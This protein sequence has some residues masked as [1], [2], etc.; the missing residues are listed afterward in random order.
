MRP[1]APLRRALVIAR[2]GLVSTFRSR[3]FAAFL[4][5]CLVPSLGVLAAV[6][7]RHNVALVDQ[8]ADIAAGTALDLDAWLLE[9]LVGIAQT[10]TFLIVLIV[11]PGLVAPD[12]ANNAMPLYRSRRVAKHDYILGKLLVLLGLAVAVGV[13]PGLLSFVA[14]AGY[15][16]DAWGSGGRLAAAFATALLVWTLCLS[17]VALAVSAWV[18]WRPAATLGLLGLYMVAAL[19]GAVL[20]SVFGGVAGSLF[21][22]GR[23]VQTLSVALA[24]VGEPA[25]PVGLACAVAAAVAAIATGALW[26]RVGAGA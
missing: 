11:G 13:L 5:A 22:L 16:E 17:L 3:L 23:A 7:M 1:T 25:M 12:L 18:K 8:V 6:Y 2:Y 26:Y 9:A 15:A 24:D 4:V 21:D 20:D 19:L 10:V 14:N